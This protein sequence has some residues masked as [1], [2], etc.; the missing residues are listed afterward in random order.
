MEKVVGYKKK[1]YLCTLIENN[2][3]SKNTT[4]IDTFVANLLLSNAKIRDNKV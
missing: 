4:K 2:R 3:K 1:L